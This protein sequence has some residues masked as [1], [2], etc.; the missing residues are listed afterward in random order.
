MKRLAE[1]SALNLEF[2]YIYYPN[3]S[4][5]PYKLN[6]FILVFFL[7]PATNNPSS[8]FLLSWLIYFQDLTPPLYLTC[9]QTGFQEL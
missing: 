3:P 9:L 8:S 5:S 7:L 4:N 1:I 6:V 2:K